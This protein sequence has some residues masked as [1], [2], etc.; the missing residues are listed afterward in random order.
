VWNEYLPVDY[1]WF[2]QLPRAAIIGAARLVDCRPCLDVIEDG[3]LT[4]LEESIGYWADE[5]FAYRM[6]HAVA[7]KT[8]VPCRGVLGLTGLK[9]EIYQAAIDELRS[10]TTLAQWRSLVGLGGEL[11]LA[12]RMRALTAIEAD[13]SLSE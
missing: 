13:V 1:D 3:E 9:P 12:G 8:P 5:N 10:S 7:F 11:G 4:P 6:Q 2:N